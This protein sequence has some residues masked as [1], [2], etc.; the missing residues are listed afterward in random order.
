MGRSSAFWRGNLYPD[1]E[2]RP[3]PDA[4]AHD[5]PPLAAAL[6][7]EVRAGLVT[8]PD[9]R[10]RVRHLG[11]NWQWAWEYRAGARPLCWLHVMETGLSGTFTV[12]QNEAA[13]LEATIAQ[14]PDLARAVRTGQQTGPVRWCWMELDTRMK[15]E[16]LLAFVRARAGIVARAGRVSVVFRHRAG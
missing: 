8:V 3:R 16:Q 11:T 10:E 2:R 9:L 14:G 13:D 4:P 6:F 5:L 15:G 12:P 1:P 7:A